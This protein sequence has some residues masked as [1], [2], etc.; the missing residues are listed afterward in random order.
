MLMIIAWEKKKSIESIISHSYFY[1][2]FLFL[3]LSLSLS[4]FIVDRIEA[5]VYA[6]ANSAKQGNA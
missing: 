4:P 6:T 5:N 1:F 3:S 2:L